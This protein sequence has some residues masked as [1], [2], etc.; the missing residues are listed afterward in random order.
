M[1]RVL[2]INMVITLACAI[3]AV[4]VIFEFDLLLV[5]GPEFTWPGESK[6]ERARSP[7]S[8]AKRAHIPGAIAAHDLTGRRFKR[9]PL[10]LSLPVDC[11]PGVDCWVLNYVDAD[12][13]PGRADFACGRMTYDGHK[14]TDI[15]LA[16][17]PA[18]CASASRC[19]PPQTAG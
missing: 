11:E 1:L 16:H 10:P 9:S 8:A 7:G 12:A 13:G 2:I 17:T 19:E 6:Q 18:G 15:A 14:G 4:W 5:K 3:F